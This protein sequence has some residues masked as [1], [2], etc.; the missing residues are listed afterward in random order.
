MAEICPYCKKEVRNTKAL[1]S[2]IHYA[3]EAEKEK[4]NLLSYKNFLKLAWEGRGKP[5][6]APLYRD[7]YLGLVDGGYIK[8]TGPLPT[9]EDVSCEERIAY[10]ERRLKILEGQPK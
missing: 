4:I 9:N 1:G 3:H 10:L 6:S 7:M 8:A 5:R 2:H